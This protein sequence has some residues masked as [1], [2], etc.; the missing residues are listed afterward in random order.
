MTD[1]DLQDNQDQ[2]PLPVVHED[3][4]KPTSNDHSQSKTKSFPL[5]L[6]SLPVILIGVLFLCLLILTHNNYGLWEW[7]QDLPWF[8]SLL[9]FILL[10]TMVSF[11]FAFGYV[12]LLMMCGYL[13]GFARGML[14]VSISVLVGFTVAFVVCRSLFKDY[15]RGLVSSNNTLKAILQV[16]D[17]PNGF[18]ILL[19]IRLTPIPF[20]LQTV[21]FAVS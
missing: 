1:M 6:K 12:L 16:V 15:T 10:F 9:I 21:L 13:Y 20:G 18:R 7:L 14:I 3:Q 4:S 19:L 2:A 5:W 8:F 11:P 17:G